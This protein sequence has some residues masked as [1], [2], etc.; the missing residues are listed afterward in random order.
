MEKEDEKIR[1]SF[2]YIYFHHYF[3]KFFSFYLIK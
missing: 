2:F 1:Y 3:K